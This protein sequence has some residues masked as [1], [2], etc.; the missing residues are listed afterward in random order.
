MRAQLVIGIAVVLVGAGCA[1]N[2][3]DPTSRGTV[4]SIARPVGPAGVALATTSGV[5]RA[6]AAVDAPVA[7]LVAGF[8]EAG[9][10]L[11]RTQEPAAN[12]V[13]SPASIGHALLMAEA[14]GDD[15]T[16]AAIATAFALPEGAHAAWNSIDQQLAGSQSDQVT[17]TIADRIWPSLDI[18][19]DQAWI[20][21]LAAQHG[22]DV[23]PLDLA[24]DPDGSRN[25]IN[26]VG[27]GTHRTPHPRTAPTRLDPP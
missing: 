21:L 17:L 4:G 15:A 2:D 5:T 19:P 26:D 7:A 25:E 11:L 3:D 23:V 27:R 16:R 8:N 20:D 22:A 14:A 12:V 24:G 10:D 6:P 9:F 13:F 18:R 1:A